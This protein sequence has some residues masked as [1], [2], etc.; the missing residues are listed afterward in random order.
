MV[1]GTGR[2]NRVNREVGGLP[3]N[4]KVRAN[5]RLGLLSTESYFP[6]GGHSTGTANAAHPTLDQSLDDLVITHGKRFGSNVNRVA[7]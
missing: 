5:E 2:M 4:R 1:A 6:I 3:T 7:Q